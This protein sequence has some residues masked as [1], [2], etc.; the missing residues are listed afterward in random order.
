MVA[1]LKF[2]ERE[3]TRADDLRL[4][5]GAFDGVLVD[6]VDELDGVEECGP[7]RV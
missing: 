5:V 4:G 7:R 6:H 3:R 2:N 1:V